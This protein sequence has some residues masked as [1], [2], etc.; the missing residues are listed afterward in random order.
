M[1]ITVLEN[2]ILQVFELKKL[3]NKGFQSLFFKF[4]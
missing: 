1:Y 4:L 3:N 2:G